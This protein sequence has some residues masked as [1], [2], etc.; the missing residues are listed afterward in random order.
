MI[1][2]NKVTALNIN[3][4]DWDTY[5]GYM[6][7]DYRDIWINHYDLEDNDYNDCKFNELL[8][9]NTEYKQAKKL[10]KQGKIDY[11]AL[12]CVID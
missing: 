12:R 9:L 6:A 5:I 11:I 10:L 7:Y 4:D 3:V 2:I 8:E 1:E